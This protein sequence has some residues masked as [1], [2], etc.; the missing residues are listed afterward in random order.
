MGVIVAHAGNRIDAAD[1]ATP[2]FPAHQI[3]VVRR[4]VRS[5]LGWLAPEL[6]VSAAAGGADLIVL[7]EAA[8][9]S[10]STEIVLPLLVESFRQR[11]VDDQGQCWVEAFDRALATAARIE[12]ADH[13]GD[14]DWARRGNTLI[15]DRAAAVAAAGVGVYTAAEVVALVVQPPSAP[16]TSVT[17]D[18]ARQAEGK[19][20]S[21]VTVDPLERDPAK[22]GGS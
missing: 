18:F 16:A 7:E 3:G 15:L 10:I 5:V 19:G 6:V 4:R 2:R 12:T 21:V 14:G 20:W 22:G 17:S 11:S 13:S 1:R 8:G 9:L